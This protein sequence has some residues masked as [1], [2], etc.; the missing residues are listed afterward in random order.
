M[1]IQDLKFRCYKKLYI[2][3]SDISGKG[4]FTQEHINSGEIVLSFGGILANNTQR[5][6]GSYL[7]NTFSGITDNIMICENIDS[8]KDYSDYLNHSCNPNIGMDDCITMVAIRDILPGE[9]LTFDYAFCEADE[10][11]TLDVTCNCGQTNCRKKI[12]GL[13]WREIKSID[14]LFPFYSPFI[15]RRILENER[16][17]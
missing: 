9:E 11:W 13:D 4:L 17:I 5:Y 3:D 14:R 16:K 7:D 15:K 10:G 12:T 2:E 1:I 8:Q 6:S